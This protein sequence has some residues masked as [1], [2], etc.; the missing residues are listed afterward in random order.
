MIS[1]LLHVQ[2]NVWRPFSH[3]QWKDKCESSGKLL[4]PELESKYQAKVCNIQT[5]A[6]PQGYEISQI[7]CHGS[8]FVAFITY[9]N[10]KIKINNRD[11]PGR[12]DTLNLAPFLK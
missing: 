3:R 1:P 4:Q 2:K 5:L 10:A 7:L 9:S 11:I 12:M 6:S 8:P